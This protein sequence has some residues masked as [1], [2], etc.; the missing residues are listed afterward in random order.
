MLREQLLE[1]KQELR[2]SRLPSSHKH[3]LINSPQY[4]LWSSKGKIVTPERLQASDLKGDSSKNS[5]NTANTKHSELDY[6][7]FKLPERIILEQ[8]SLEHEEQEP[9]DR[10]EL[11]EQSPLQE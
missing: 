6:V 4:E 9:W 2:R 5:D 7:E 3:S 11:I 8:P 10:I 1:L